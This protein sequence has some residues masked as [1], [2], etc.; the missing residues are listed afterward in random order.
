MVPD[1]F[2]RPGTLLDVGSKVWI[3]GSEGANGVIWVIDK[4]EGSLSKVLKRHK[5]EIYSLIDIGPF[6]W[7]VS[8][9]C[10]IFTWDKVVNKFLSIINDLRKNSERRVCN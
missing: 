10:M 2:K 3:A 7:S 8:W 5:G 1:E 9:D 6:I 4:K